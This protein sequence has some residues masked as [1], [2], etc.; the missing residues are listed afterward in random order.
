MR[1]WRIRSLTDAGSLAIPDVKVRAVGELASSLY[2]FT[3]SFPKWMCVR[4]RSLELGPYCGRAAAAGGEGNHEIPGA[5]PPLTRRRR[6][7]EVGSR[8]SFSTVLFLTTDFTD[9]TD[10]DLLHP[11]DRW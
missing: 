5:A 7:S 3:R 9:A 10:I 1:P 6:K 4:F 2:S 8:T 11:C